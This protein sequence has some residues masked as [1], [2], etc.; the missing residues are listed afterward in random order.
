MDLADKTMAITGVGGFIGLRMAERARDRGMTV[1]G[2][3]LS[4]E[5]CQR[6]EQ[7]G[8]HAVVGDVTDESAVRET[9][10]NTDIVFHTAAVVG[11]D[12]DWELY[13][14][15]NVEGTRT[16][17]SVARAMGIRHAVHLSS[18]MVYGF[19]F[20]RLVDEEGPQRGEDNPYC[21]TKIESDALALSMDSPDMGVTVIRPGDVYGPGCESWVVRPVQLMSRGLFALADGGRGIMNHVHVDN[22]LDAVFL[23]LEKDATGRA[24]NVTD[25]GETS[26]AEYFGHF[27]RML[28]GRRLRSL[29]APLMLAGFGAV[30]RIARRL[31]KRPPA[32]AAAVRFLGRPHPY[33][34]QRARRELG[35]A[36]QVTLQQGMRDLEP[37][38]RKQGLI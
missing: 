28:G 17:L 26:F 36:P 15:V 2:L 5:G 9:L 21:Q 34:I 13:R 20:P 8:V 27:A 11:E 23:A 37:W 16:V 35:Y 38:L 18:V 32:S 1:R 10:Q 29:P 19:T 24:F 25:G 6:A 31:G 3:D 33:S 4:A 30:E 7:A 22:L 14:R 12:G